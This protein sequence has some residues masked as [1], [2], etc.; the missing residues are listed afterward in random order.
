M[1]RHTSIRAFAFSTVILLAGGG[2]SYAQGNSPYV[3]V[4][5][6][7]QV[8][9][10][11]TGESTFTHQLL[12]N[13]T[14]YQPLLSESKTQA[15]MGFW[16]GAGNHG[17]LARVLDAINSV[18][19]DSPTIANPNCAIWDEGAT[20][21]E[22]YPAY[23]K[24]LREHWYDR[25]NTKQGSPTV[26]IYGKTYP[27]TNPLDMDTADKIWGQYSQRYA[28]MATA[29][30]ESTGKPVNVWA[31]VQGAKPNRIFYAYEFPASEPE[32]EIIVSNR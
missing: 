13:A 10:E 24:M 25:A 2:A 28:D 17:S 29:L 32:Q 26:V 1:R 7:A 23:Y 20:T 9:E 22:Q 15:H 4:F 5:T 19:Q 31:F 6:S 16:S 3:P 18:C 12:M 11:Q 21:E 27:N 14:N 30:Y 8:K